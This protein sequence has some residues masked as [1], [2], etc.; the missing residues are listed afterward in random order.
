MMLS[1]CSKR[2]GGT[3]PLPMGDCGP[4]EGANLHS[5]SINTNGRG[6]KPPGNSRKPTIVESRGVSKNHSERLV[7]AIFSV[8]TRGVIKAV[9]YRAVASFTTRQRVTWVPIKTWSCWERKMKRGLSN[10]T[11]QGNIPTREPARYRKVTKYSYIRTS[12]SEALLYFSAV[13]AS[14]GAMG[15]P[16]RY[17]VNRSVPNWTI[18]PKSTPQDGLNRVES[19]RATVERRIPG[20]R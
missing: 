15:S 1:M 12:N 10:E 6:Q 9:P 4:Q 20:R 11:K 5:N 16:S 7:I 19:N 17:G 18:L 13:G 8:T 14:D 3:S 2:K